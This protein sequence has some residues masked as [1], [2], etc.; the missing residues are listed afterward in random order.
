MIKLYKKIA[1]QPMRPYIE[2][3]DLF[4]VSVSTGDTPEEGGMVAHSL[5]DPQDKWYINPTFFKANYEEA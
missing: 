1:V 2:G 3:E 4:G 5:S